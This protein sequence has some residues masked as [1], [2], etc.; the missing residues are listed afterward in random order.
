MKDSASSSSAANSQFSEV[1][2][3][4]V[5]ENL[6][7][8]ISRT[9]PCLKEFNFEDLKTATNNFKPEALLGERG[10]VETLKSLVVHVAEPIIGVV[11]VGLVGEHDGAVP[12]MRGADG[13]ESGLRLGND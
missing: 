12:N 11:D 2:C 10:H 9:P 13:F 3:E 5:V 8:Q 4:E 1:V 7:G 6:N